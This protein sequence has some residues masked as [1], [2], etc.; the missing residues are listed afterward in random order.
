MRGLL[1]GMGYCGGLRA[2]C[3][4]WEARNRAAPNEVPGVLAELLDQAWDRTAARIALPAPK[5]D[6]MRVKMVSGVPFNARCDY[7]ARTVELNIEPILTR[8][9]LRH[10]VVHECYPGHYAQFKLRGAW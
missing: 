6:G 10:L 5:S 7:L 3:A 4:A 9:A 2:Q 1:S 8:P